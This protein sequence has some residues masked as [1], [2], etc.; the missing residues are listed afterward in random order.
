LL[1]V[2]LSLTIPALRECW[3]F[4]SLNLN[5]P[6]PR[7]LSS[8]VNGKRWNKVKT[9][10]RRIL[11]IEDNTVIRDD[12]ADFLTFEG[13]EV[14]TANN[15]DEGIQQVFAHWP[16]LIVTDVQMPGRGGIDVYNSL[17]QDDRSASIPLIFMTA[18]SSVLYER[19]SDLDMA[20]VIEKP[21]SIR[22]LTGKISQ[23][24]K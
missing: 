2:S 16:D 10:C 7:L 22:D 4:T 9:M 8:D 11:I 23:L 21:F 15:G 5:L 24:L 18:S 6:S 20:K 17:Q 12:V 13:Y 14:I 3:H 19:I 1:S